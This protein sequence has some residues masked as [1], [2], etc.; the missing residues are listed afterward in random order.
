LKQVD[1]QQNQHRPRVLVQLLHIICM[2]NGLPKMHWT[3]PLLLLLLVVPHQ[4]Q[5]HVSCSAL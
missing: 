4:P 1:G 3:I 2:M 5:I